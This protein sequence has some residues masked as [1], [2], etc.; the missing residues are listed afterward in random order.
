[1]DILI[2]GGNR[3]IGY[4]LAMQYKDK[5]NN[6]H[7]T[8]RDS[9]IYGFKKEYYLDLLIESSINKFI[10]ELDFKS[11][12]MVILNSAI[13][14]EINNT[15]SNFSYDNILNVIKVNTVGIS[16]LASLLVKNIDIKKLVFVSSRVSSLAENNSGGMTS[17]RMSKVALNM[18]AK[19]LQIEYP[20]L[21]IRIILPG[22]TNTDMGGE[23]ARHDVK[24]MC[25]KLV[26][27]IDTQKNKHKIEL[28][29][30]NCD[31]VEW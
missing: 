31:S 28:T 11:Y 7:I 22:W 24:N 30:F 26:L 17:Y 19:N 15:V 16:Y 29:D 2:I 3:G 5:G 10:G 20:K 12:D 25:S 14:G 8:K 21:D 4:E 6:V 9:T 23:N 18:F 13:K 27:A 1:M